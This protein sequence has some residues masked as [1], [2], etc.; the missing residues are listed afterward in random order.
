M[1]SPERAH[2]R[3]EVVTHVARVGDLELANNKT[4][5]WQKSQKLT[6]CCQMSITISV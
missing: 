4:R 6:K 2:D 1:K 5:Q 3:R